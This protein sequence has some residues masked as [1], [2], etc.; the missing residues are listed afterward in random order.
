M[1]EVFGDIGNSLHASSAFERDFFL[2][3][4]ALRCSLQDYYSRAVPDVS[5]FT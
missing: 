4:A 5:F 3:A 2:T 1:E